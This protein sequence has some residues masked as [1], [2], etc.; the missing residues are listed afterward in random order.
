MVK[1]TPEYIQ[2]LSNRLKK[3]E[4]ILYPTDTIWGL[5]CDVQN[6]AAIQ[7]IYQIKQRPA[8]MPFV[9]LVSDMAMLQ[10][11][12]ARIPPKAGDLIEYYERPLTIIYKEIQNL[13]TAILA[14]NGT[15]AIRVTKDPFCRAFIKAFGG[16]VVSTSAN[17]SGKP[18]P[19]CF[20]EID[21]S[22]KKGVDYIVEHR[23]EE[24]SA[25]SPSVIVSFDD[26]NELVFIRK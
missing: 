7:K 24:L 14:E 13:P 15:V 17:I 12:V 3:G 25:L 20:A 4:A 10:Q 5:G 9:L 22:I 21:E 11:Y 23:Q 26:S 8:T 1:I 19:S 16:A 18:F 6:T 2:E